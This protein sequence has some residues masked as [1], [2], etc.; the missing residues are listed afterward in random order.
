MRILK[1][2]RNGVTMVIYFI[3]TG[4][5]ILCLGGYQIPFL[6]AVVIGC[7]S[8]AM[9]NIGVEMFAAKYEEVAKRRRV[10]P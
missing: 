6:L 9:I 10:L 7:L 5:L 2:K 3:V 1:L 8:G 4:L